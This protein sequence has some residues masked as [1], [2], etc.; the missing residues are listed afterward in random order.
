MTDHTAALRALL[1][2]PG[3][4]QA[5]GCY[6][7]FS[8][9]LVQRAGFDAAYMTGFGA[10]ASVLGL[11]DTGYM[12]FAEVLNQARNMAAAIDIPLIADADTGY[13]NAMNVLRTVRAYAQAGIA[14]VQLEDQV[15]PKKCGH[16]KGKAVISLPEATAKIRAAVDARAERD[17]VIVA[18]T[19]ARAVHGFDDALAR[20]RAFEQAGADVIFFEAPESKEELQRVGQA[21]RVPLLVNLVEGGRTPFLGRKELEALG[22]KLAIYPA[23]LLMGV[24]RT[25]QELLAELKERDAFDPFARQVSFE[26]L[27]TLVGFDE[28]YAMEDKYAV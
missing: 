8:A 16:T 3:L 11:P 6:D 4:I 14:A 1:K 28:Y 12:S 24:A 13:G 19:D 10:S 5:P 15:A 25:M 9:R 21:L 26:E 18:R 17:I 22:F 2:R 27:K 7:A 23:S 20:C